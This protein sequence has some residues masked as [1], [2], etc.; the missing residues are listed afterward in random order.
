MWGQSPTER[1]SLTSH[2][3]VGTF[4]VVVKVSKA[5]PD[6]RWPEWKLKLVSPDGATFNID[7]QEVEMQALTADGVP[8]RQDCFLSSPTE[9]DGDQRETLC[10]RGSDTEDENASNGASLVRIVPS[11]AVLRKQ[12]RPVASIV[13][14]VLGDDG[15]AKVDLR[16]DAT[17]GST[18]AESEAATRAGHSFAGDGDA[19]SADA[20]VSRRSKGVRKVARVKYDIRWADP[21][22][23][24]ETQRKRLAEAP[25]PQKIDPVTQMPIVYC[26]K[27]YLEHRRFEQCETTYPKGRWVYWRHFK[28]GAS[29]VRGQVFPSRL[30]SQ[31]VDYHMNK[32]PDNSSRRHSRN[33]TA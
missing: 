30:V 11:A 1:Q 21:A 33:T 12:Q 25:W 8:S 2:I 19:R 32:Q 29:Y 23:Y 9:G 16:S 6:T 22:H 26:H 31:W 20:S 14:A 13:P 7:S 28:C 24:S 10:L 3:Q 18:A 5:S 15:K 4:N 27:C 17:A